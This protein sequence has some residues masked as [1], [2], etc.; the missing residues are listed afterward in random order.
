MRKTVPVITSGTRAMTAA[1]PS[2]IKAAMQ[3]YDSAW[4]SLAAL[5]T[6]ADYNFASMDTAQLGAH[7]KELA[8]AAKPLLPCLK[9][10]CQITV[11]NQ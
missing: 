8:G 9:K 11:V 6:A 4:S 3:K 10:N 2:A 7:A 5:Y 1:A